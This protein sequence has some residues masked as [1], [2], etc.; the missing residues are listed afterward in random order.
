MAGNT[1]TFASGESGKA[2]GPTPGSNTPSLVPGAVDIA[3]SGDTVIVVMRIPGA[4]ALSL[5][6]LPAPGDGEL[7]VCYPNIETVEMFNGTVKY[8]PVIDPRLPGG[9]TIRR[10]IR[11]AFVMT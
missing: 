9:F 8:H 1:V 6:V 5:D 11:M 4:D 3:V 7:S 2:A 10:L